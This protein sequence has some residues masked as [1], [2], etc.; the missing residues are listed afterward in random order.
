[1]SG[2]V[3]LHSH[4]GLLHSHI[5]NAMRALGILHTGTQQSISILLCIESVDVVDV[6]NHIADRKHFANLVGGVEKFVNS[7]SFSWPELLL[8][9][10]SLEKLVCHL[11]NTAMVSG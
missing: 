1:M 7:Q 9:N 2:T 5:E 6:Y 4:I 3:F 10:K 8:G 11:F